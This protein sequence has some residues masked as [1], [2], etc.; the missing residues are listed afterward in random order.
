MTLEVRWGRKE[1][2][3]EESEEEQSLSDPGSIVWVLWGGRRYPAKVILMSDVPEGLSGSLRKDDGKSVVVQ[4]Y[5]DN[6]YSRVD[7][8]KMT[9]LG[10]SNLDLKWSR[11]S[12]VMEKYNLALA[13]LKYK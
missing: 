5:G 7:F 9:E 13:G 4:F 8:R 12:G 2:E 1:T 6:D 10:Q 11:F 3:S